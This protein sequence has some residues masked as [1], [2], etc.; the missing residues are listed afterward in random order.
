MESRGQPRMPPARVLAPGDRAPERGRRAR[1]PPVHDRVPPGRK[2]QVEVGQQAG[3]E[4]AD[5]RRQ[6]APGRTQAAGDQEAVQREHGEQQ[7]ERVVA[8][9]PQAEHEADRVEQ[10]RAD[11]GDGAARPGHGEQR[12][13]PDQGGVQPIDLGDDRLAPGRTRGGGEDAGGGRRAAG[14]PQRLTLELRPPGRGRETPAGSGC[15]H[16]VDDEQRRP[17]DE[18]GGKRRADRRHQVH[19]IGDVADRQPGEEVS[20]HGP[21]R[22]AGFVWHAQGVGRGDELAAVFEGHRRCQRDEIQKQRCGEGAG[23]RAD[24]RHTLGALG[25]PGCAGSCGRCRVRRRR[26]PLSYPRSSR[27]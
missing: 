10:S 1:V 3:E 8:G 25:A 20:D 18:R 2:R 13:Q 5:A 24:K 12:Q 14:E 15:R 17:G 6:L 7:D 21:Q 16:P 22:I 19:A 23:K 11:P 26:D 27:R 9:Q 4:Q